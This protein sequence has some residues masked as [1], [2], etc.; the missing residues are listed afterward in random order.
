M[1]AS[2]PWPWAEKALAR[3]TEGL[4]N[5]GVLPRLS[6]SHIFVDPSTSVHHIV[7]FEELYGVKSWGELIE[8]PQLAQRLREV[9]VSPSVYRKEGTDVDHTSS[10]HHS[11]IT[12]SL[13]LAYFNRT[14]DSLGGERGILNVEE[15]LSTMQ[16][17]TDTPV[18]T[19]STSSSDSIESQFIIFNSF[20]ILVTTPG[21]HI[22][23]I[24]LTNSTEV[25]V[26]EV[27]LSIRDDFWRVNALKNLKIRKYVYS[28]GHRAHNKEVEEK[29]KTCVTDEHNVTDCGDMAKNWQVTK[30]SFY[31][32][33]KKVKHALSRVV[34]D[35]CEPSS[36]F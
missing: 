36:K 23:N 17:F 2:K 35:L 15:L 12:R 30:D 7:C 32:N 3:I 26:I 5:Q 13:R 25:G 1:L 29:L 14:R 4:I 10:L 6:H 9:L 8:S 11:C 20:D 21:S 22:A 31:V 27:G 18:L 16:T 19:L 24:L 28:H 33:L 34:K